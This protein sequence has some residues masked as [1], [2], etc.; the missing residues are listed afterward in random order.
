VLCR[1]QKIEKYLVH[2][3]YF[4]FYEVPNGAYFNLESVY[5]EKLGKLTML[6]TQNQVFLIAFSPGFMAMPVIQPQKIRAS[7]FSDLK[8]VKYIAIVLS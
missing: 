2:T 6:I 3:Q 1:S 4:R 7:L 8:M 5:L